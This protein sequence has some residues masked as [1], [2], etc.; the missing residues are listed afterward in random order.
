MGW[1]RG[2][3][4]G[5]SSALPAE[6][7]RDTLETYRSTPFLATD[8]D[9]VPRRRLESSSSS[10][11]PAVWLA[12][13]AVAGL[14]VGVAIADRVPKSR[15]LLRGIGALLPGFSRMVGS[16][17]EDASFTKVAPAVADFASEA[18]ALANGTAAWD[19][20]EPLDTDDD[21]L[22][23]DG[24]EDE[25]DD[26]DAWDEDEDADEWE[27]DEDGLD[28][29]LADDG[30][31]ARVLTAFDAD[32]LL[33]TLPIE[34]DEPAPGTIALDGV[35][36]SARLIAHAV[37]IARGTPGVE[38]VEHTLTVRRAR[39]PDSGVASGR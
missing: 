34:I 7:R 13:G 10:V 29:E 1:E 12:A 33:A 18:L 15:R 39:R 9:T 27:D 37:T 28:D 2:D 38:R 31:D 35:V 14:L 22:D 11:T 23:E 26:A 20:D 8:Q 36:P 6:A 17:D 30:L 25:D 21:V 16:L 3:D 4:N 5:A 32:P 24:V 19:D